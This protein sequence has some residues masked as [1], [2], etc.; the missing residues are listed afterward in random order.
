MPGTRRTWFEVI[1]HRLR[2]VVRRR[3]AEVV[4]DRPDEEE[5]VSDIT[6]EA[7]ATAAERFEEFRGTTEPQLVAWVCAIAET[8]LCDY[9]RAAR[10]KCRDVRRT[11]CLGDLG[12]SLKDEGEEPEASL[13]RAEEREFVRRL[14]DGLPSAERI[15][16]RL[17]YIEERPMAEV[18]GSLFRSEAAVRGLLKRGLARL[19]RQARGIADPPAGVGPPGA[20]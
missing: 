8:K 18:A 6:Q 5:A 1:G 11:R 15:A 3:V 4:D 13:L 14:I 19:R 20:E 9:R 2:S 16:I 17:R 10:A 12:E 7:M